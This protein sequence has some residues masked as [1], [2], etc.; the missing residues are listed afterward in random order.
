MEVIPVW[1]LYGLSSNPFVVKPI[2]VSKGEVPH[3]SFVGRQ[4]E[5]KRLYKLFGSTGGSRVIVSGPIG[6]GKTTFVNH[7]RRH[8][9]ESGFFSPLGE[10]RVSR[11]WNE[12]DFIVE[13]LAAVYYSL[14]L[15][16]Q[17]PKGTDKI[18]ARLKPFF[19]Q[20]VEVK[21]G[22]SVSTPLGG[23]GFS[24][25][26][27]TLAG[28]PTFTFYSNL[29]EEVIGQLLDAGFK[30]VIL[31][32]NNFEEF[33]EHEAD[34]IALMQRLR[35]FFITGNVHFVFVAA[36]PVVP[37]LYRSKKISE[38]LSDSPIQLG[39]LS[40][41]EAFEIIESR[42]RYLASPG[43]ASSNP[44]TRGTVHE[45]FGLYGGSL[46]WVLNSLSTAVLEATNDRP[47]LLTPSLSREILFAAGQKRFEADLSPKIRTVLVEI[48]QRRESTNKQLCE[49]LKVKVPNMSAY[50]RELQ[51][52]DAVELVRVDGKYRYYAV[53]GWAKWLKL[54][55]HT[56]TVKQTL[57][58]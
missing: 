10:I 38:V 41:D 4:A 28:V 56:R 44:V 9:I 12:T 26:T 34:L 27:T 2:T 17:R 18:L 19:E 11:R 49:A 14:R 16:T 50:L 5:L 24:P 51:T 21:T 55:P 47:I 40:K 39:A 30:Q 3:E 46:R 53:T 7:A 58:E 6:V 36:Q 20:G 15:T 8:A 43:Y 35:D 52:K 42:V 48:N 22:V 1:E 13:T 33:E 57:L 29:F 23:V 31:H 25:S 37:F 45:L 32:Y 54:K